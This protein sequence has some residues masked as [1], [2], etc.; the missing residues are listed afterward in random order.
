VRPFEKEFIAGALPYF[1]VKLQVGTHVCHVVVHRLTATVQVGS[2]S[3]SRSAGSHFLPTN[4]TANPQVRRRSAYICSIC[5]G[6]RRWY[7]GAYA[8]HSNDEAFALQLVEGFAYG[9]LGHPRSCSQY[10]FPPAC[11]RA[12]FAP[13][14]I[15]CRRVVS[16]T[17][18]ELIPLA[19]A[20]IG[21]CVERM[22]T[23]AARAVVSK[24]RSGPYDE[25]GS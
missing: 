17:A 1:L 14:N 13:V 9:G 20:G 11:H 23:C 15:S 5:V 10:A 16:Y 12:S 2:E 4:S 7:F 8:G 22:V 19:D 6:D 24:I 3:A 21:S 25:K 18:P